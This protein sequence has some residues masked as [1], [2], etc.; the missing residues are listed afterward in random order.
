M[1]AGIAPDSLLRQSF[2]LIFPIDLAQQLLA[3]AS[4]WERPHVMTKMKINLV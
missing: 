3:G 4:V 2:P 1:P